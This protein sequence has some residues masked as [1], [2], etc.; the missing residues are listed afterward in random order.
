VSRPH[1]AAQLHLRVDKRA[2]LMIRANRHL[3]SCAESYQSAASKPI[4]NRIM[5]VQACKNL[6]CSPTDL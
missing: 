4:C 3:L 6:H 5:R 1:P 2:L